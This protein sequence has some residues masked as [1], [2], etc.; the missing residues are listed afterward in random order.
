MWER[1]GAKLDVGVFW[2]KFVCRHCLGVQ[3]SKHGV[4]IRNKQPHPIIYLLAAAMC[5][6]HPHFSSLSFLLLPSWL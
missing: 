2:H 6:M 3:G 4:L 1:V 5:D